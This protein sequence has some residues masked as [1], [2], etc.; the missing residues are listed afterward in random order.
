ML[1]TRSLG[2]DP[3]RINLI[4]RQRRVDD[5][6]HQGGDCSNRDPFHRRCSFTVRSVVSRSASLSLSRCLSRFLFR[7]LC[8][9][10]SPPPSLVPFASFSL[11]LSEGSVMMLPGANL[12]LLSCCLAR[13]CLPL[14]FFY[15]YSSLTPCV[16]PSLPPFLSRPSLP[17]SLPLFVSCALNCYLSPSPSRPFSLAVSLAIATSPTSTPG[18][19]F[20]FRLSMIARMWRPMV[21]HPTLFVW[22]TVTFSYYETPVSN[23]LWE[24][25]YS[26]SLFAC[27]SCLIHMDKT[28]FGLQS[29]ATLLF[30]RERTNPIPYTPNPTP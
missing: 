9:S 5:R 8:L 15:P 30:E 10:F 17:P 26:P 13:T 27:S 24:F 19:F 21:T 4:K 2:S 29:S 12:P 11:S 3:A 22:V 18:L 20:L 23:F 14:S 28:S 6:G 16:S 7:S 1:I 25:F